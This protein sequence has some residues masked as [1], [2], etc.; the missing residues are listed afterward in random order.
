MLKCFTAVI[1]FGER[2]TPPILCSFAFFLPFFKEKADTKSLLTFY[3]RIW[4]CPRVL[5]IIAF[6]CT[7]IKEYFLCSWIEVQTHNQGGTDRT[8]FRVH[9]SRVTA[10][11]TGW[12][13][14]E[15]SCC[16]HGWARPGAAPA[17][18]E[19]LCLTLCVSYP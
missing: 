5:S 6:F 13:G 2:K 4:Q 18:A 14:A 8:Y 15:A 19:T 3:V 16:W 11:C 17:G 9:Q 12:A 1:R 7:S 10:P